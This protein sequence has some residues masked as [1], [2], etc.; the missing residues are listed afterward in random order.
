MGGE[1]KEVREGRDRWRKE[2]ERRERGREER[3]GGRREG[4]EK[5][6]GKGTYHTSNKP[7][8]PIQKKFCQLT[9][10]FMEL[11]T[12]S[13][14]LMFEGTCGAFLKLIL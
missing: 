8:P 14:C 11:L 7:H 2:R 3:E 5:R 12:Y 10:G 13:V 1:R 9:M 6:V 4:R